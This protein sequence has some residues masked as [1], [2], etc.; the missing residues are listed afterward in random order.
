MAFREDEASSIR[1]WLRSEREN[2]YVSDVE[3]VTETGFGSGSVLLG[4]LRNGV[5][6]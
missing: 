5:S 3:R 1:S 2:K 6:R 4:R